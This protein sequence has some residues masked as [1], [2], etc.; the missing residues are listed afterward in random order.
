MLLRRPLPLPRRSRL[1]NPADGQL[2]WFRVHLMSFEACIA[3]FVLLVTSV[4]L[5]VLVSCEVFWLYCDTSGCP[6]ICQ[7]LLTT[8]AACQ[9]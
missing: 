6:V 4:L 9:L 5:V 3:V 8:Q 1:R 2:L 7:G